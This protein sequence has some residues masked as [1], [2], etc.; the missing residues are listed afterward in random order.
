M[1]TGPELT[2]D[3]LTET[4]EHIFKKIISELTDN[5]IEQ[6]HTMPDNVHDPA[7]MICYREC[8]A[9]LDKFNGV[10]E[11]KV[12]QFVG[13]IERIGK[14]INA[15][16]NILYCMCTSKLAGEAKR[17]YDDNTKLVTWETLKSALLERFSTSDSSS[18]IFEQLKERKQKPDET[19]T[20]Y[21]DAVIK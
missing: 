15:I 11:H 2:G 5:I 19:I 9:N 1:N 14:M 10:S 21:Y 12:L 8:L 17:W 3:L 16:D 6:T 20:S 4:S 7:M 18:K 13:N